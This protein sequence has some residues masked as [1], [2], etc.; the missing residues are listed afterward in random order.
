MARA[1][2]GVRMFLMKV[3]DEIDLAT[4]LTMFEAVTGRRA[5]RQEIEEA[6]LELQGGCPNGT[7]YGHG[8][9]AEKPENRR[10]GRRAPRKQCRAKTTG[11]RR[12]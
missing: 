1:R 8:T 2:A 5:T 4:V 12:A 11:R 7:A 6:L 9:N 10:S 3:N